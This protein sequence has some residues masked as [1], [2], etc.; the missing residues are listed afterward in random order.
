MQGCSDA[1]AA[2]AFEDLLSPGLVKTFGHGFMLFKRS[3]RALFIRPVST[4]PSA[5]LHTADA[6]SSA[7]AC[8]AAHSQAKV[9]TMPAPA[10]H[11]PSTCS[12]FLML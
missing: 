7:Q 11:F 8:W 3:S 10:A 2:G 5:R 6:P 1:A 4:G 12:K 9:G